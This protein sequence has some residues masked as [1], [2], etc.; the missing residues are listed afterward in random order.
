GEIVL[1]RSDA[2]VRYPARFQLV[3][4]AN[5]CPC[6]LAATPG[7]KCSCSPAAIR[8]YSSRL[9]GPILDRIDLHQ[10]LLP[11]REALL[12]HAVP[13]ESS[14]QVLE[15]VVAA[16]ERQAARLKATP[17]ATNSE[18]PGPYL[19]RQLPLPDGVGLVEDA[20]RV[21]RLSA[22]GVDKVIKVAWTIADLAG[23]ER[24]DAD[25][26]RVALALRQGE[27]P[28]VGRRPARS[29]PAPSRVPSPA[30][31][32]SRVPAPS[33][34]PASNRVP[35]PAPASSRAPAPNPGPALVPNPSS[36]RFNPCDE[37]E[38]HAA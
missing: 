4:A 2:Q 31:A 29:T 22:R 21:G 23:A 33:S 14:A 25:H 24:P 10:H 18:V 9:S 3:L 11:Q 32:S 19:R 20:V 13:G 37:G 27:A 34:N 12:R 1:S 6:G 38:R 5:P 16:R 30:P 8:R 15:R 7:S 17:W 26:V 28:A 36:T 35:G